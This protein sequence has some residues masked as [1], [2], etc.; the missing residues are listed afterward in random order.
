MA[1]DDDVVPRAFGVSAG[2]R[3]VKYVLRT[4]REVRG[5]V[6]MAD[7]LHAID[8]P[9]ARLVGPIQRR[10]I[11]L[12]DVLPGTDARLPR[13][14]LTIDIQATSP[15]ESPTAFAA[16]MCGRPQCGARPRDIA[17]VIADTRYLVEHPLDELLIGGTRRPCLVKQDV[18]RRHPLRG[19]RERS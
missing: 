1:L 8:R 4:E 14:G 19:I 3:T 9:V 5:V 13:P 2:T 16:S 18:F 17:R 7:H 10:V 15:I 12:L 11:N 6:R